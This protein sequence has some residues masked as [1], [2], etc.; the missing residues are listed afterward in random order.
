MTDKRDAQALA[1]SIAHIKHCQCGGVGWGRYP[2]PVGHALFGAA[3]PCVCNRD[4]LA[5]KEAERL[6]SASGLGDAELREWTF[7]TF[8]P[9]LS[10]PRESA[11]HRDTTVKMSGVLDICQQYASDPRGWLV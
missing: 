4:S 3:I 1:W 7:E 9:S 10:R 5:R 8:R 11:T 6:Q 2:F